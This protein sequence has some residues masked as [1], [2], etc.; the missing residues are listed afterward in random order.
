[1]LSNSRIMC[2]KDYRMHVSLTRTECEEEA[3]YPLHTM[4]SHIYYPEQR[5]ALLSSGKLCT[6]YI[7]VCIYEV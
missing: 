6:D 3:W 4:L 7:L 5:N 2:N 1:M